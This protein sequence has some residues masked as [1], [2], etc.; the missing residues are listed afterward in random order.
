MASFEV[1][2]EVDDSPGPL[3]LLWSVDNVP[4]EPV[5]L[6]KTHQGGA[7]GAGGRRLVASNSSDVAARVSLSTSGLATGAHNITVRFVDAAGNVG[8]PTTMLWVVINDPPS[9]T[10][11]ERPD[12]S[13]SYGLR[14]YDVIVDAFN[15][16]GSPIVTGS[17][18]DV[19]GLSNGAISEGS[20]V[21]GDDCTSEPADGAAVWRC[22]IHVIVGDPGVYV[23]T[24]AIHDPTGHSSEVD[25][26]WSVG[27]CSGDQYAEVATDG[28][29]T[30]Q[31]CPVGADCDQG[32]VTLADLAAQP[33]FW[34]PPV[35]AGFSGEVAFYKVCCCRRARCPTT[36]R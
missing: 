33:E 23:L 36:V 5:E 10:V 14:E 34:S 15:A 18:F 20:A 25:V 6:A 12:P 13:A 30:C 24:M 27:S 26:V 7:E 22:S 31:F 9:L 28:T 2:L 35:D 1:E 16:D 32:S 11:V 19:V 29:L 4:R 3:V 17:R 8:P 21:L